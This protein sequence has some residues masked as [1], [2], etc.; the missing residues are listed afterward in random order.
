M[1]YACQQGPDEPYR[2]YERQLKLIPS[3]LDAYTI[4]NYKVDPDEKWFALIGRGFP[5]KR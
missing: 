5:F 4:G 3:A 2:I 1:R